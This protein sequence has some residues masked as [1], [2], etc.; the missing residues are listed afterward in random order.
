MVHELYTAASGL[1]ICWLSIRAA[2]VVLSWMPQ[3][4]TIILTKVH[5]WSLMVKMAKISSAG[6]RG[7]V[8][9]APFFFVSSNMFN[10]E[11]ANSLTC[12][13]LTKKA[14]HPAYFF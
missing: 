10:E 3:G 8:Y 4:R 11:R 1:Y 13:R 9:K 14:L 5:E 2:T 12:S 7:W 6:I